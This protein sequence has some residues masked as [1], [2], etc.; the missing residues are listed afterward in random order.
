MECLKRPSHDKQLANCW[1]QIELVSNLA[2]FF[3]NFFV[4]VNSH[5]TCERLANVRK[6]RMDTIRLPTS[7]FFP[8]SDFRLCFS[9]FRLHF[10]FDFRLHFFPISDFTFFYRFLTSLFFR[11]PTLL[12]FDFQVHFFL[13]IS[14]FTF[15]FQVVTS[16]F[17]PNFRLHFL[18][19]E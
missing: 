18:T 6:P 14:D 2:N 3:T 17:S 10:F 19:R 16:L 7:L 9:D 11:F 8:T 12:F 15:F 5:V 13:P 4:L 1:R